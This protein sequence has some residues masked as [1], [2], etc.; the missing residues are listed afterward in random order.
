MNC[1]EGR[2]SALGKPLVVCS[3]GDNS[4]AGIA[5]CYNAISVVLICLMERLGLTVH[6]QLRVR[7]NIHVQLNTLASS[8]A[9]ELCFQNLGLYTITSRWSLVVLIAGRGASATTLIPM[10]RPVS[11]DVSSNTAGRGR[12]LAV[13]TP[14]AIGGLR[15]REAIRIYNGEDIEVV[16][17]LEALGSRISGS[18]ELIGSVFHDLSY[19]SPA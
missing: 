16:L 19:V 5:I 14:H 12:G 3:V 11:V 17:V 4:R 1:F 6:P 7:M 8:N 15:V 2:N 18:K 13:L 9:V 10:G